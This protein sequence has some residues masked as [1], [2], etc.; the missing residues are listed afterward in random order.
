VSDAGKTTTTMDVRVNLRDL[1]R[2][3]T[4]LKE[5]FGTARA[6]DF[7][8]GLSTS[9]RAVS[10]L[11]QAT[12]KLTAELAR[13][14]DSSKHFSRMETDIRDARREAEKL[15]AE[16]ER[17]RAAGGGGGPNGGGMGSGGG[18][19]GSGGGS[20]GV[21]DTSGQHGQ[22]GWRPW[23]RKAATA[24]VGIPDA[25]GLATAMS[26]IPFVGLAAA[27]A[28]MASYSMYGSALNY[29]TARRDTFSQLGPQGAAM[30]GL[31]QTRRATG[32][33]TVG[34]SDAARAA[35]VAGVSDASGIPEWGLSAI[36]GTYG[37]IDKYVHDTGVTRSLEAA[38]AAK[39][40]E[41]GHAMKVIPGQS[42][43][44][45]APM[46]TADLERVGMGY[47]VK[48]ADALREAAGL[49]S[50]MGRRTSAGTYDFAR[51]AQT[52]FGVDVGTT[53]SLMGGFRK[54][55]GMSDQKD[56]ADA[57][58]QLIGNAVA[59]GLEGSE[60]AAYLET[61]AGFMA[62]QAD[63]GQSGQMVEGI[64]LAS[65][66][67]RQSGFNPSFS[68]SYAMKLGEAGSQM[69]YGGGSDPVK[70]MML[71][72]LGYGAGGQYTAESY[73]DAMLKLQDPDAAA[74]AGLNTLGTF[75]DSMRGA[76]MSPAVRALMMSRMTGQMGA[77]V[78]PD[79]ARLMADGIKGPGVE[80]DPT[81][82]AAD[83]TRI[84]KEAGGRAV[85]I[86][87]GEAGMEADR[88]GAGYK[89]AGQ[90]Q[91]LNGFMIDL[92]HTVQD[93]A[94][95]ALDMLTTKLKD[96][97]AAARSWHPGSETGSGVGS[98]GGKK[99]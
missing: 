78:G 44:W 40:R 75:S 52:Y 37:F 26:S 84:H 49:S 96:M 25:S 54:A 21:A 17:V 3:D 20:G 55:G 11:L 79:A 28:T 82:G 32:D 62:K 58:A 89:A 7:N 2:L 91:N 6:R 67:L 35:G 72:K 29:Q 77:Q 53:G 65:E 22:S 30:L 80:A 13:Q 47:G 24:Q 94:G 93:K 45:N 39:A 90:V 83:I 70:F 16:L 88:I 15:R 56:Q 27:G 68:S 23:A 46:S 92:A 31:R 87:A 34:D 5:T 12:Q 61:M 57:V 81:V 4:K 8:R 41:T 99:K 36:K 1:N 38:T 48:P 14:R 71:Q 85:G 18:W 9:E 10:G 33:R 86:L 59:R 64:V 63:L 95:P 66:R 43:Q 98:A 74:G 97:S 60:I 19:G 42:A 73:A 51:S 50:A 69:G 76:G